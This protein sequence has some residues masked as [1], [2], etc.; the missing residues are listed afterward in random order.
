MNIGN[1]LKKLMKEKN[2]TV[3]SLSKASGVP[4]STIRSLISRDSSR[5]D[6]NILLDICSALNVSPELFYVDYYRE[7]PENIPSEWGAIRAFLNNLSNEELQEVKTFLEFLKFKRE[8]K[9][10]AED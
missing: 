1:T 10:K 7:K 5:M 2:F 8:Q 3:A 6:V 9:K 4:D